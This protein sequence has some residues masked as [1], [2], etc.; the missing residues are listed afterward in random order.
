MDFLIA[1]LILAV[2]HIF[3]WISVQNW[4]TIKNY[5]LKIKL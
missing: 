1:L 4:D 3:L 5:I 2:V